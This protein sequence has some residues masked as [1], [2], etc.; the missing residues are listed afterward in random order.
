MTTANR[1]L[2]L[3]ACAALTGTLAA[4]GGDSASRTTSTGGPPTTAGKTIRVIDGDT[5]DPIAGATV[6]AFVDDAP[7]A[8]VTSDAAGSAAVPAATTGACASTATYPQDCRTVT[9]ARDEVTIPLFDPALQSPEYGGGPS[10]TRYVPAVDIPVPTGRPKWRYR[11]RA[12]LE[13][14]PAVAGGFVALTTNRGRILVYDIDGGLR[15]TRKHPTRQYPVDD[16]ANNI[17][18]SPAIL[19]A[20]KQVIVTGMDGRI[21]CYE[22][23]RGRE[24]WSASTG[25]SPIESSPLVIGE[26]VYAGAWNGRLYAW[27]TKTGRLRWSYQAAADIKASAAQAGDLIIVGDYA[28]YVYGLRTDGTLVWRSRPG[29]VFYSGPAVSEGIA[30]LGDTGGAVVALNA[31]SGR[32]LWRHATRGPVYSSAAIANGTVFIGSYGGAFQALDLRT[33]RV[34]WSFD[35]GGRISGSATVVGD[36]VYFAVLARRGEKDR[37]YALDVSDGSVIREFDDGRYS[38]AVGAGRTLYLVGRT[39]LYAY[40]AR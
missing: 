6:T 4:C 24:V 17:A 21:V 3:V 2:A 13:F 28:G 22:L 38:P 16:E 37:T 26:T 19:A 1:I 36:A 40:P 34:K 5:R 39:S 31:A 14:P 11:G 35:A 15:W 30:V 29:Q 25:R 32:R 8:P 23:G 33:G 18:S 12:L 9:A 7:Q 27:S 10:R 20:E